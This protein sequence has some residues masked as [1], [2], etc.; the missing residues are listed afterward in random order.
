MGGGGGD[1]DAEVF[2][3]GAGAAFFFGTGISFDDFAE[4][5]H[6]GSFL[7]EFEEG[8]AFFEVSGSELE[9]FGKVGD[10]FIVFRTA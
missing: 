2:E 4:F 6:A 1:G 8:H 7:V 3:F 9:T 5:A 10:D